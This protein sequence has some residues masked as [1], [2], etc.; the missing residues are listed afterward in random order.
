MTTATMKVLNKQAQDGNGKRF[1]VWSLFL[2]DGENEQIVPMVI[3]DEHIAE[4]MF[5]DRDEL[6][7][8]LEGSGMAVAEDGTVTIVADV[9]MVPPVTH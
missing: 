5:A 6:V 4:P 7:E 2:L 8:M 9:E 1:S 3:G